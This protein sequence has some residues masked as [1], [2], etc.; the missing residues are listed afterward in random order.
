MKKNGAENRRF[1]LLRGAWLYLAIFLFSLVLTQLLRN[2]ASAALFLF[3]LVLPLFDAVQHQD[4][5]VPLDVTQG[6]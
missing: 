2:A 6:R 5:S 4:L 1:K 3:V